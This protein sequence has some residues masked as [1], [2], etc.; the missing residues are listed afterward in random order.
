MKASMIVFIL[1]SLS[2]FALFSQIRDEAQLLRQ[3]ERSKDTARVNILNELTK[4]YYASQPDKAEN[5]ASS[6]LKLS[7][8][9]GYDKGI[10]ISCRYLAFLYRTRGDFKTDSIY[11]QKLIDL[12]INN[13]DKNLLCET[14]ISLF[15]HHYHRGDYNKAGDYLDLAV[16]IAEELQQPGLLARCYSNMG[17]LQGIRGNHSQAV[18]YDLKSMELYRSLSDSL[19]VVAQ[20]G[21]IGYTFSLAGSYDQALKYLYEAYAFQ[22][23]RND[24]YNIGWTL[25]NIGVTYSHI[26]KDSIA[27]EYYNKSLKV[28]EE[29]DDYRLILTNLDN[30]GGWYSLRRDFPKANEFLQKAYILSNEVGQNSR[31]VFISGNLA[32]NY[33]YSDSLDKAQFFGEK[34]LELALTQDIIYEQKTAYYTLAQIYAGQNNFKGAHRALM[35]YIEVND[36][37][38]NKEKS[39]QIESLRAAYEAEKKEQEIASLIQLNAV[40]EFRR[41]SYAVLAGLILVVGFLIYYNQRLKMHKNKQLLEKGQEVEK[42]QSIFFTNITHEFRTPLTLILAPIATIAAQISEPYLKRQL[43]IMKKNALRLMMLV[44]QL[45]DLAKLES[46]SL[47]LNVAPGNIITLIKGVTM[48]FQSWAESKQIDLKIHSEWEELILY[49]DQDKIEK[50]LSNLLSNS[51]KFT[52]EGGQIQVFLQ[53]S[54]IPENKDH[55]ACLQVIVKDTGKGIPEEKVA[56][57]FDRYYQADDSLLRDTEGSGIGLAL[58][59]E[60]IELHHGKIQV[61]S[62]EG[63]GTQMNLWLPLGKDHFTAAGIK[64]ENQLREK[65][66]FQEKNALNPFDENE[67]FNGSGTEDVPDERKPIILLIE[68]NGD[69]RQYMKEILGED[70]TI[71]E[72]ADGEA[73]VKSTEEFIPDLVISDVMMPKMDGYEVCKALKN[74]EKTSHIPIL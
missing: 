28:A 48:S 17:N 13:D 21:R 63:Q 47:K 6:A 59:K 23:A 58:T 29:G 30:I 22:Q 32:E 60:F 25:V 54:T 40:A 16:G 34:Q 66:S 57:I 1:L 64:I 70:Y 42:M 7:E 3:L 26:G 12:S 49:F 20:L 33:L 9:L 39:Q 46:G 8:E 5:Y 41:N 43:S 36:S 24:K 50:V 11:L 56:H 14:N 4:V 71:I 73:G 15:N 53:S 55:K 68:D 27:L 52:E 18:E 69:V 35:G 37:I 45:L 65:I 31:T 62:K 67:D 44:N 74:L 61:I 38:F 2:H 51:F 19:N 10:S 72:A